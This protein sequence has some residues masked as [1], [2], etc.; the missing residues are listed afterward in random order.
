MKHI[1]P[2]IRILEDTKEDNQSI[3]NTNKKNMDILQSN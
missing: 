1:K 2:Q 3:E